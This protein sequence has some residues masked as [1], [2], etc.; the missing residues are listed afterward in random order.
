MLGTVNILISAP[1]HVVIAGTYNGLLQLP[2]VY[3]LCF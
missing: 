1:G 3:L 2:N